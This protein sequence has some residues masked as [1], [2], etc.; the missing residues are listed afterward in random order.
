MSFS[1]SNINIEHLPTVDVSN[2]KRISKSFLKVVAFNRVIFYIILIGLCIGLK[3][4]IREDGFQNY[5]WYGIIALLLFFMV[6]FVIAVLA[7]KRRKYALRE[8]DV[9]YSKGLIVF[10]RITIPL[11][12]V[13]HVEVSQSWLERYLKLASLKIYTAGE[14]GGDLRIRGLENETA[15]SMNAYISSR[16]NA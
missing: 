10:Y 5:F 3:F 9:I 1:N 7:F 13:Q 14:S 16:I 6:D 12:R 11:N 15:Q 2:L 8:H 4:L